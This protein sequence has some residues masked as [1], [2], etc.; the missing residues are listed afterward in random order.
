VSD[1][2]KKYREALDSL[3][4]T[5]PECNSSAQS[6]SERFPSC[7]CE[8]AVSVVGGFGP[9][10]DDELL[11]HFVAIPFAIKPKHFAKDGL[12]GVKAAYLGTINTCGLSVVRSSLADD[13]Q[14]L[15]SA[16]LI[17]NAAVTSD[18]QGGLIGFFEFP[19]SVV[20]SLQSE[21]DDYRQFCIY[22]TPL[23]MDKAGHER[24]SHADVFSNIPNTKELDTL[25]I[26]RRTKLYKVLREF[27]SS[28][29]T[30]YRQGILAKLASTL[31]MPNPESPPQV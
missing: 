7:A 20:R 4:Q 18:G 25:K 6:L 5:R 29:L 14:I 10:A 9:I 28:D 23:D 13:P 11:L 27:L 31:I 16:K 8:A 2:A 12:L 22:D 30:G 1:R 17:A 21:Q 3:P 24:P 15:L 19:I 26:E